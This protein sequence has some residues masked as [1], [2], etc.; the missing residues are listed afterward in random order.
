M[1]IQYRR[2]FSKSLWQAVS[3]SERSASTVT[4][5]L[6][7]P[8]ME[9]EAKRFTSIRPD[10]MT[11]GSMNCLRFELPWGM[12]GENFTTTGLFEENTES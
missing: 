11:T 7:F 2:E 4:A 10:T 12:F 1:A 3:C 8:S 6:I 5:S 9:D